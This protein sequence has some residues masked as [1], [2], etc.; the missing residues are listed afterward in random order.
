MV[1]GIAALLLFAV[2]SLASVAVAGGRRENRG[3]SHERERSG[4]VTTQPLHARGGAGGRLADE[5]RQR[6][7]RRD[8]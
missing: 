8:A 6:S 2:H 1:A 5:R 4:L 7:P 3:A